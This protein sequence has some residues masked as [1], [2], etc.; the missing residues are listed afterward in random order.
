MPKTSSY[1]LANVTLKYGLAIA[2]LGV[3]GAIKKFP[4]L[5]PGINVYQGKL[6]Y[7]HISEAFPN[8]N[9][10]NLEELMLVAN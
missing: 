10:D 5:K 7:K 3:D 1:A 6:V 2:D 9:F 8:L 4:E